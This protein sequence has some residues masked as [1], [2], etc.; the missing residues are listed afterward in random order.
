MDAGTVGEP[1]KEPPKQESLQHGK[2]RTTKYIFISVVRV[3]NLTA[4]QPLVCKFNCRRVKNAPRQDRTDDPSP[5][6]TL[7]CLQAW[8]VVCLCMPCIA[9]AFASGVP[10]LLLPRFTAASHHHHLGSL[11]SLS[12][13]LS[14]GYLY[15]HTNIP[16]H[17]VLHRI[18]FLQSSQLAR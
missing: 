18:I 9:Q 4:N 15:I 6:I 16:F 10:F 17:L 8:Q 7:S 3:Q 5:A 13:P 2:Q 11:H 1:S 14:L 12:L